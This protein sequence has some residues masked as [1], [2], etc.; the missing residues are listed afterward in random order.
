M[1]PFPSSFTR[2]F[3]RY[4]HLVSLGTNF[5]GNTTEKQ[6]NMD[7]VGLMT[8]IFSSLHPYN[9]Q[10]LKVSYVSQEFALFNNN[11]A[12]SFLNYPDEAGES[13]ISPWDRTD[14]S[15]TSGEVQGRTGS[16]SSPAQG[17][18]RLVVF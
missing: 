6:T 2:T 13:H 14:L 3:F 8:W 16:P 4:H 11:F 18:K 5:E 1:C 9:K 17:T 10:S 7:D 15:T 12:L